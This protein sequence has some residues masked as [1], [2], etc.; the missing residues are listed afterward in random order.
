MPQPVGVP[1]NWHVSFVIPDKSTFSGGVQKAVETGVVCAKARRD[2]VHTLRTLVL[3]HARYPTSEEYTT[4]S[5][6]LVEK[7]PKLHDGGR[8]GFVSYPVC[9]LL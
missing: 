6:K 1:T 5:R 4:V 7:F 8:I 9:E 2:I 3:Q